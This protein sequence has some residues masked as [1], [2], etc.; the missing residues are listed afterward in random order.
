MLSNPDMQPSASINRW[1]VAILMFHFELVHVKGVFHGPNSLSR[2]PHQPDDPDPDN[3]D[4]EIYEDWIDQM[5]GFMHL[6][7]LLPPFIHLSAPKN[8]L[9]P[10]LIPY[11]PAPKPTIFQFTSTRIL[12]TEEAE[13]NDSKEEPEQSVRRSEEPEELHD[14]NQTLTYDMVPQSTKAKAEEKHLEKV[15]QWL[16]DMKRPVGM[17]DKEYSKFIRYAMNFF[18]NNGR[19]WK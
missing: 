4:N 13:N 9:L 1:I 14:D 7:Q 15:K 12:V 17:D 18:A 19:L 16:N 5:Y 11:I 6:I 8:V 2:R 3:S 10:A